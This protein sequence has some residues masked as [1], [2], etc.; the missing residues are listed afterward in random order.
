MRDLT[1]TETHT[2]YV[3]AGQTPVLVHN[4]GPCGTDIAGDMG[5]LPT[6]KQPHVRT[7][8]SE[9]ELQ[10]LYNKWSQGGTDI[11]P[12]SYDGRMVEL[13]DGTTVGWR[14]A[15]KSGGATI[16]IRLPGGTEMKVHIDGP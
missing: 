12:K 1:I 15:S 8:G 6:G 11:T 7:V 2:Y 5:G 10:G 14:N 4:T 3:L 9:T 16:D 13:P